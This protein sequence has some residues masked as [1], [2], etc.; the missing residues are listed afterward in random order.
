[1]KSKKTGRI[2][3]TIGTGILLYLGFIVMAGKGCLEVI[4]M[5]DNMGTAAR[6]LGKLQQAGNVNIGSLILLGLATA[7]AVI[8]TMYI[9]RRGPFRV[10]EVS[11]SSQTAQQLEPALPSGQLL[12]SAEEAQS[13]LF[14][15]AAPD[16]DIFVKAIAIPRDIAI[17]YF[18]HGEDRM[19]RVRCT[20]DFYG[21]RK[22]DPSPY[23]WELYT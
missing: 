2:V 23:L 15:V 21:P 7:G 9:W 12:G 8:V 4:D 5:A 1:M 11:H 19:F 13:G 14:K 17:Q 3:Q 20:V 16:D 6:L 18:E 22:T 10:L